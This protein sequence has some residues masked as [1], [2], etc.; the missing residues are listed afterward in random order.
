MGTRSRGPL[1][2]PTRSQAPFSRLNFR[3]DPPGVA[4]S[5]AQIP[6]VSSVS[7]LLLFIGV[8]VGS[9]AGILC[10]CR[11]YFS[12][13]A[14]CRSASALYFPQAIIL[15]RNRSIQH[16]SAHT[17]PSTAHNY[18]YFSILKQK[19]LILTKRISFLYIIR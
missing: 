5:Y 16:A 15:S 18:F 9:I 11:S 6:Y 13:S 14:Q 1:I 8:M 10:G 19:K 17:R 12:S 7:Q 2:E 3:A 4:P